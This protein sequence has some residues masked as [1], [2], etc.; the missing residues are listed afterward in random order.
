MTRRRGRRPQ[1]YLRFSAGGT[2]RYV[3]HFEGGARLGDTDYR[4]QVRPGGEPFAAHGGVLVLRGEGVAD[5]G[6]EKRQRHRGDKSETF[7]TTTTTA[8]MPCSFVLVISI[9][10]LAD[11]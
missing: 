3:F 9:D 1:I 10:R 4:G 2:G 11:G 6:A 8:S 5:K 7:W